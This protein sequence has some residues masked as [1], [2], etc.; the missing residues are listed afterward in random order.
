MAE[1]FLKKYA[2]RIKPLTEIML[3][4]V[5]IIDKD[6]KFTFLSNSCRTVLGYQPEELTG[7]HFSKII[8][9]DDL[10]VSTFS[11]LKNY[12]SQRTGDESS[13]GLID[14][15]RDR[16]RNVPSFQVTLI[17]KDGEEAI[18]GKVKTCGL[19]EEDE[20]GKPI[21]YCGTLGVISI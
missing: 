18:V 4:L 16:R 12:K 3:E 6:G 11:V 2:E 10:V 9:P 14:E 7:K 17:P 1:D 21:V 20:T 15:K 8:Y 5:Y 19:W 13:P